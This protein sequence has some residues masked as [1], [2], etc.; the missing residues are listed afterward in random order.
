MAQTHGLVVAL[1]INTRAEIGGTGVGVLIFQSIRELLFNIVKHAGVS[2]AEI[3][4]N[5]LEENSVQITVRDHGKG[6]DPAK[7]QKDGP[8]RAGFG[9]FS[10]RERLSLIG[11][12]FRIDSA[13]GNGS[14]FTM[15]VPT[16]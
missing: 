2:D 5:P 4:L 12:E 6:F 14:T 3:K 15:V 9:L 1:E 10:I 7:I 11:C 16:Y 13:V 8:T